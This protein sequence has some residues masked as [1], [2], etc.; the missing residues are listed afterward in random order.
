MSLRSILLLLLMATSMA[1]DVV[2]H[3]DVATERERWNTWCEQGDLRAILAA[4]QSWSASIAAHPPTPSAEGYWNDDLPG[5]ALDIATYRSI[6]D[7][8]GPDDYVR[9]RREILGV[10]SLVWVAAADAFDPGYVVPKRIVPPRSPPSYAP[11][12]ATVSGL[13]GINPAFITDPQER[14]QYT[15]DLDAYEATRVK[16][17]LQRRLRLRFAALPRDSQT[18]LV[19]AWFSRAPPDPE[20]AQAMKDLARRLDGFAVLAQTKP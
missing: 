1:G 4:S 15:R 10:W 11:P 2:P 13:A 14:T 3:R 17:S 20:S 19:A 18:A 12:V 9:M 5:L 8:L 16:A 7:A 6:Y